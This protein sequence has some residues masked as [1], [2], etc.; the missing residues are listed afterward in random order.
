MSLPTSPSLRRPLPLIA[1]VGP[2]LAVLCAVLLALAAGGMRAA[3]SP[4]APFGLLRWVGYGGIAAAVLSVPGA[5]ATRP[6]SGRRGFGLSIVGILLGLACFVL[7]G[8]VAV[9]ARPR[10]LAPIGGN[11]LRGIR[12]P[13]ASHQT[14]DR[15]HAHR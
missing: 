5:L 6:G 15:A 13:L 11:A 4:E 12:A 8:R 1:V 2:L 7:A 9:G 3:V 10:P 14:L